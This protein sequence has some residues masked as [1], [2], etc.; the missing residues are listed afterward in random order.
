MMSKPRTIVCL[1]CGAVSWGVRNACG[2]TTPPIRILMARLTGHLT[3]LAASR[4]SGQCRCPLCNRSERQAR[5]QFA[6]PV[7]HPERITRDLPDEQE[8]LLAVL[9]GETWPED[10]YT[11]IIAEYLGD[12]KRES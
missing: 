11:T 3:A 1:N 2:C 12:R 4:H 9:A 5:A 10:E 8:E 6:M 7:R